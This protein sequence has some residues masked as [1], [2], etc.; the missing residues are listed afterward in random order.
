MSD[1]LLKNVQE[2]LNEEKWTR[3]T[4]SNYSTSQFK[5][6]DIILKE[7]RE[8][9]SENE[10]KKLCDEH[11]IHTKNSIIALYLGGMAALSQQIIDDSAMVSLVTIFVDNHKWGIVKFLC[12]RIL[13][14]GES[15]FALRTLVDCHKNENEEEAIYGIWERLVKVDHDEADLAKT[16]AEHFEKLNDLEN[17]IDYYKKALHRYIAKQHFSNVKEIWDKLLLFCPEEIDFYLHVQ[18]RVAKNFDELKAGV[19]LKDVYGVYIKRDDINTAIAVLKLVL[20]YDNDD[21]QARKDIT[22]CYRKK[23]A[24]HSQLEA[25]IRISSL[26]QGPR[27]VKE[28]VQDFE[29]HIAFDKGNFVFHRTWGVGR[30]ANVQG[31]DIVI[32]FAKQRGHAMSLKMAVNA[33]QTL[34]KNHIWVLKATWKKEKLYDKVK[35]DLAWTLKTVIKSFGNSCDLKRVKSELVP[36]VLTSSEWTGWNN[37]AREILKTDPT[38]GLSPENADFYTVRERPISLEEKLYN[39]FKAAKNFFDRAQTIRNFAT[40]KGM[41]LDSEYFNEMF[42]Y[43]TGFLKSYNQVNEQIVISYLLVKD[44]VIQYPH[45]GTGIKINFLDLF[46]GIDDKTAFF[47]NLKDQK[48]KE[49]FLKNIRLYVPD[50]AEIFIELFPGYPLPTIIHSLQSEGHVDKLIHMVADCFE[51]FREHRESAVWLFRNMGKES[52]FKEA[53]IPYEKQLITLIHIL[54]N[55]YREIEN[56]KDTTDNKKLSKQVHTILFKEDVINNF[57]D[58]ADE[59]TIL[60][61]YS[62]I[63]DVK[64]LDP[65]DKMNLRNR[66]LKTHPNFKFFG[67]EEKKVTSIGLLVTLAMYQE[68]QRQLAHIFEVEFPENSRELEKAKLLGDL[69]ENAEHIAAKEEQTRLNTK[70]TKLKGEI[71][72]AILFDPLTVNTSKISFG[73]KVVLLNKNTGQRE[74]Y[75]ILGPWESDP[76]KGIISYQTPFGGVILNKKIGDEVDFSVGDEIDSSGSEEK[77]SYLVENISSAF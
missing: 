27:N 33:L 68:K 44:L 66:I 2:M 21:R 40:Q 59:E 51:N 28:A 6:L 30:I 71:D 20:E 56:R 25:Y 58:A 22:D 52:W 61:I 23:Y 18:K 29:K 64:D 73:T 32:D 26:A 12:E 5:E 70:A 3:A 4:L 45:L 17:A 42:S 31:D 57:L 9:R 14:Y 63:N 10:L 77:V 24:E 65:Q 16:L 39:E 69:K 34:S 38:F 53:N 74:N 60:R 67:D 49:E 37:K 36:S 75:T 43:F 48:L 55:T 11:L 15:K 35:E 19:L 62:F 54:D 76:D 13:D 46:N 50:W 8:G 47:I 1:V 41:E 7:S 72:K